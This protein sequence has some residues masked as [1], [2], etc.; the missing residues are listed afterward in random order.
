MMNEQLPHDMND[1]NQGNPDQLHNLMAAAARSR[2]EVMMHEEQTPAMLPDNYIPTERD[3]LTGRGKRNWNHAGNVAFRNLIQANVDRYM[4]ASS[5]SAKTAIVLSIVDQ[6]RAWPAHFLKQQN[7]RWMD[8][9]DA[10]AREKVGHS[11]RDQVTA[12][13][14]HQ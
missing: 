5:K 12:Y 2:Q 13:R 11:L 4:Q 7:G 1:T 6:V 10:Q 8:I 9:G 14:F 3:I